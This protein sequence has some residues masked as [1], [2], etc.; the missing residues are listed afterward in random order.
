[1]APTIQRGGLQLRASV[2]GEVAPALFNFAQ[3]DSMLAHHDGG[4]GVPKLVLLAVEVAP[5]HGLVDLFDVMLLDGTG[6]DLLYGCGRAR[7][8]RRTTRAIIRT[9]DDEHPVVGPDEML[10][11]CIGGR[12]TPG[13]VVGVTLTVG[14]LI[15]VGAIN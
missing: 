6:A 4:A 7:H 12:H 8:P 9:L 1:M 5:D 11:L 15:P 10:S 14:D 3:F 2:T 13:A